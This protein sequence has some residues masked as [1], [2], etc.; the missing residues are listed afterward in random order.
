MRK[1]TNG[2]VYYLLA[3]QLGSTSAV[4]NP[5]TDFMLAS[6]A[7]TLYAFLA[8]KER[9]SGSELGARRGGDQR[10]SVLFCTPHTA[11]I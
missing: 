11:G 2:Q 3:D 6:F 4:V 5:A 9:R 7:S 8:E 1:G 10:V